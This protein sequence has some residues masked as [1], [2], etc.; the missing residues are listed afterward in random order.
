MP[1]RLRR[2]ERSGVP[3]LEILLL[4]GVLGGLIW[5]A[6]NSMR[7]ARQRAVLA[8]LKPIGVTGEFDESGWL[9]GLDATTIPDD[10]FSLDGFQSLH[11][12]FTLNLNHTEVTDE[13]LKKLPSGLGLREL[14]LIGTAIGD[15]GCTEIAR[16]D[17]LKKLD[18]RLTFVADDGVAAF[19]KLQNLEELRLGQTWVTD[20]GLPS[21]RQLRRLKTLDL[22]DTAVTDE[23]LS[24]LARLKSLQRLLLKNSDVTAEGVSALQASL[25]DLEIEFSPELD[26]SVAERLV[27]PDFYE[28]PDVE[29][30]TAAEGEVCQTFEVG[31]FTMCSLEYG[32]VKAIHAQSFK[33]MNDDHMAM[34]PRLRQLQWLEVENSGV[35]DA[36]LA[37]LTRNRMLTDLSLSG[38]KITDEGLKSLV[39]LP[40]LNRLWLNGLRISGEGIRTLYSAKRLTR[41]GISN[42]P[43]PKGTLQMLNPIGLK[44]LEIRNSRI[45]EEELAAI[46]ELQSLETLDLSNNPFLGPGLHHLAKLESLV[47]LNLSRT[48]VTDLDAL[49]LMEFPESLKKIDLTRAR[50]SESVAEGLRATRGG[51]TILTEP[52]VEIGADSKR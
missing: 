42:T 41:L 45:G 14:T 47:E 12:I 13:E 49:R 33:E 16:H 3:L 19:S 48:A 37:H 24:T 31:P 38:T 23:G 21:L 20:A 2:S 5:F 10:R 7:K 35:T 1:I 43:L 27:E 30:R 50:V 39:R 6:S 18:V 29:F 26:E 15:P 52:R 46:G 4:V 17:G 40:R 22:R 51:W 34:L 9:T 8:V 25:P 28:T 11:D 36:G 32:W 44:H